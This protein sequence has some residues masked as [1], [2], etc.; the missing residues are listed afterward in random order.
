MNNSENLSN[1]TRQNLHKI[2]KI[3]EPSTKIFVLEK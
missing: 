1:L 3:N 2:N